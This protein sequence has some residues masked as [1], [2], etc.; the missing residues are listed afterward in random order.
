[1]IDTSNFVN[2]W[3]D[4]TGIW[5]EGAMTVANRNRIKAIR[6]A[7]IARNA[8]Q[9]RVAVSQNCDGGVAGLAR[10]CIWND[11]TNVNLTANN[12]WQN[13]RYK[14]YETVVPLRNVLWNRIAFC[15]GAPC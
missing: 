10:V 2:E 15:G 9:E 1:Q 3:V 11:T 5:S 7:V 4:A 12:N 6:V 14:V 13:Y 8:L